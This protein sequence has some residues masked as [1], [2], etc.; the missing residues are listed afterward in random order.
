MSTLS[1]LVRGSLILF[2]AGTA[3]SAYAQT[4]TPQAPAAQTPAAQ[5]PAVQAPAPQA[6]P[7]EPAVQPTTGSGTKADTTLKVDASFKRADANGDGKLSSN[8][9]GKFPALAA[10]FAALD[11]DKDGFLSADE[12]SAAMTVKTSN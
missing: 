1:Q 6:T 2:I 9:A 10:K 12:F 8:E 5:T 11:K 4:A 7:A 3:A